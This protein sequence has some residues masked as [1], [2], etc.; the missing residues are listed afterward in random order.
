MIFVKSSSA[1]CLKVFF[2]WIFNLLLMMKMNIKEFLFLSWKIVLGESLLFYCFKYKKSNSKN[3]IIN[4]K[5]FLSKWYGIFTNMKLWHWQH[6]LNQSADIYENA[7]WQRTLKK[8]RTLK[9]NSKCVK[10]GTKSTH[11]EKHFQSALNLGPT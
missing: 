5:I 8:L 2:I 1:S 10:F 11:F 4:S 3:L 6:C 9:K 7:V